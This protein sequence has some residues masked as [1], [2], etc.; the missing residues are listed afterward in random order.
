MR[1]SFYSPA[2]NAGY[3]FQQVERQDLFSDKLKAFFW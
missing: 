1:P 3:F 2:R